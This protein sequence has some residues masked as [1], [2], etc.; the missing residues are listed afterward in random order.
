MSTFRRIICL[1]DS[2]TLAIGEAELNKWPVRLANALAREFPERCEL[3]VR[4]WNGATTFDVLQRI[5][6]EVGYLMPAT[7]VVT[8]GVNDAHVPAHRRSPQVSA[9]EF[10][11][12]LGEIHR[13]VTHLGGDCIFVAEHVPEPSSK[14]IPGN[15]RTYAENYEQHLAVLRKSA[16]ELGC[17]LIDL[18]RLLKE[19][20]LSSV[21]IVEEDGLHLTTKGNS[22]YAELIGLELNFR[23]KLG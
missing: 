14:Y 15:G 2:L 4:A 12:N 23:L 11:A 3:F 8:L 13:W 9:I 10:V 19:R 17:P 21:D 5:A 20:G 16:T 1:G 22:I 6:S 18:P 7:V